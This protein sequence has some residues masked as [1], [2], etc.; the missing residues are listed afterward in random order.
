MEN[1]FGPGFRRFVAASG[2]TNLGDGIATLAWAWVASLLTRDALLISLVPVALRLPWFLFAIPA[3]IVADRVDR[4]TLILSMD[5]LRGLAFAAAAIALW[6]AGALPEPSAEGISRPGLFI[7]IALAAVTVGVAEVFRDNAAQTMVPAIV[8]KERLEAANGRLWSVEMIGN[9]LIGPPLAALL[10]GLA[11]ALPFAANAALYGVAVALVAGMSGRFRPPGGGERNWRRELMVGVRFLI[12]KPVMRTLALVSGLWNLLFHM[13]L[14]ALILFAQE[15]IGVGATGYG[16]IL[17]AGAIGGVLAGWASEH[18]IRRLGAA[19]CAQISL[20]SSTPCFVVMVL[21]PNPW[22]AGAAMA[23]F[24]FFGILWNTVSVSYRQR[25]IPDEILGRVNSLY[26]LL[27]WGMIPLGL[28]LSGVAVR[29]AEGVTTRDV[30]LA[31]P[32][33][34]AAVGA[35]VIAIYFWRP[36]GRM[37]TTS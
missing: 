31:V 4:R 34:I 19:R 11:V 25:A 27:A 10:L 14:M 35:G 30:A 5:I 21:F 8:P 16:L 32:I 20:L 2:L 23:V 33:W 13:A 22:V 9:A 6:L 12:G 15:V 24:E 3:G 29:L 26:R 37:L 7:A 18:I 28:A 1:R 36:I 17:G